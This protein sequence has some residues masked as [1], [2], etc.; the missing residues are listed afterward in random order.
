[1]AF[2]GHI[3]STKKPRSREILEDNAIAVREPVRHIGAPNHFPVQR[4]ITV[5]EVG[6]VHDLING[7]GVIGQN[8][9]TVDATEVKSLENR[10]GVVDGLTAVGECLWEDITGSPVVYNVPQ[11]CG[12]S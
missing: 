7:E 12:C 4:N 11:G 10:G 3:G 9:T 2:E 8:D 6:C 1:M 5:K